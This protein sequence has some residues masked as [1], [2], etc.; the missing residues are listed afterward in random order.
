MNTYK[1]KTLIQLNANFETYA[2]WG[3]NYGGLQ[4]D[5]MHIKYSVPGILYVYRFLKIKHP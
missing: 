3:L 1:K 5:L 4:S 2:L